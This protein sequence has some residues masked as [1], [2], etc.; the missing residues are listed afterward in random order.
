MKKEIDVLRDPNFI[1][2]ARLA[3]D[4]IQRIK[5]GGFAGMQGFMLRVF[6]S[7]HQITL[8]AIIDSHVSA[9]TRKINNVLEQYGYK[10]EQLL[11]QSSPIFRFSGPQVFNHSNQEISGY[12]SP[13]FDSLGVY[14][15]YVDNFFVQNFGIRKEYYYSE[16]SILKAERFLVKLFDGAKASIQLQDNFLDKSIIKFIYPCKPS[17]KIYLLA[18]TLRDNIVKRIVIN[19]IPNVFLRTNCLCHDRFLIIDNKFV[20]SLGCSINGLG[21]KASLIHTVSNKRVSASIIRDFRRWWKTG[22]E[23]L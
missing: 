20:W 6:V 2:E 9:L 15:D 10:V 17:I 22:I 8:R 11:D 23:V 14:L 13:F 1:K 3:Y 7:L 12:L 19:R 5:E 18:R 16:G 4:S 21:K